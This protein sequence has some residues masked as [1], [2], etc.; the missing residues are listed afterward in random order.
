[1]SVQPVLAPECLSLSAESVVTTVIDARARNLGGFEVRRVLPSAALR[2]VGPFTF[3]DQM[4]AVVFAPGQGLDVPPHPHI[5]L[6]T[7]T[8]LFEGEVSHRDSLGSFQPIRPGDINW[9]IAGRGIVHSERTPAAH[10]P[11]GSKLHGLQLWVALPRADEERAPSFHHYPGA[12]LP[13]RNHRGVQLRVLAGT[14]YEMTSPVEIS[15]PLFYVDAVMAAGSELALPG[16]YAERALYV[17]DGAL[18]CG[19]EQAEAGRMLVFTLEANVILRAE[20]ATRVVL[21]GGA[22]L[23]GK[24][25]I[26][27][28]F[29]SSSKERLEQAKHDWKERRF[30][31]VPGDE[32]EFVPLP[33]SY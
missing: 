1:M 3:F 6:A 7:V 8:Y 14:A 29:V 27:W 19:A 33:S 32:V 26:D 24:R 21:L 5:G 25:F 30:P 17:V 4:G 23:D 20:R 11:N 15:S 31:T 28:N 9:M 13:E 22:P 16:G 2:M 12:A 18:R 10:R